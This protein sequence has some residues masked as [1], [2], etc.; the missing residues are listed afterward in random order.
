MSNWDWL[1][2]IYPC[3]FVAA[4]FLGYF[5]HK[6]SDLSDM[7]LISIFDNFRLLKTSLIVVHSEYGQNEAGRIAL[8]FALFG[9][10]AIFGGMLAALFAATEKAR[11]IKRQP[12]VSW[13]SIPIA[14]AIVV[15]LII[16]LGGESISGNCYPRNGCFS[17]M[18]PFYLSGFLAPFY[19]GPYSIVI[20]LRFRK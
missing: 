7:G 5:V 1:A 3:A 18:W 10:V 16:I 19:F 6:Y 4:Y 2:I 13:V 20:F 17:Q 8:T 11:L 12:D 14:L 15:T 9:I